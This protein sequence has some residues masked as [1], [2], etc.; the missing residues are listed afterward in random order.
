MI[1]RILHLL[2]ACGGSAPDPGDAAPKPV[3]VEPVAVEVEPAPVAPADKPPAKDARAEGFSA[4]LLASR[5]GQPPLAFHDLELTVRNPA[6][7]PRWLLLASTLNTD[8]DTRPRIL[9]SECELQ[10]TLLQ[11]APRVLWIVGV[12]GRFQGVLLPAHGTLALTHVMVQSWW[13]DPPAH[14]DLEILVARDLRIDG[15][16]LAT[17]LRQPVE[18]ASGARLNGTIGAADERM[19]PMWHP[20]AAETGRLA[21][22]VERTLRIRLDLE[23]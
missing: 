9:D 13:D 19:Q 5:G 21:V 15:Q 8:D 1:V 14:A 12:C 4:R 16:P 11:E 10:P 23:R 6:D 3:A 18:S 17:L 20:A 2:L 22:D 7:G